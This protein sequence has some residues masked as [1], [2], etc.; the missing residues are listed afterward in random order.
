MS[1]AQELFHLADEVSARAR[2]VQNEE[3]YLLA[4]SLQREEDEEIARAL[5]EEEADAQFAFLVQEETDARVA[6]EAAAPPLPPIA[7][8]NEGEEADARVAGEATAP[9]LPPIAEEEEEDEEE[10]DLEADLQNMRSCVNYRGKMEI[11]MK[12]CQKYV[13]CFVCHD[14]TSCSGA[15]SYRNDVGDTVR[16]RRCSFVG[17]HGLQCSN[18]NVRFCTTYCDKCKLWYRF[19]ESFHCD[20]CQYCLVGK[21]EEFVHCSGC[22]ICIF[23]KKI[24][25]HKC[26]LINEQRDCQICLEDLHETR[27]DNRMFRCG[28]TVHRKCYLLMLESAG[29]NAII[30]CGECRTPIAG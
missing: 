27:H 2:E 9:P 29:N 16:C 19:K 14:D 3:D 18:C 17:P 20:D 8:E 13:C 21:R 15:T 12:C 10:E 1:R 26:N 4:L 30:K 6:V 23:H 11:W 28:H 22:N 7:E 24:S 5:R 25:Y